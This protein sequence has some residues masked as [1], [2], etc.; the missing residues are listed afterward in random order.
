MQ[1]CARL[2]RWFAIGSAVAIL[3][4]VPASEAMLALAIGFLLLSGL[5]LRWPKI[6]IP[7]GLFILW[8]LLSL[9]ASP[10]PA[11]GLPQ[12]YKFLVFL[13]LLAVYSAV[14][15]PRPV[16]IGWATIGAVTASVGL[17]QF[18]QRYIQ[19]IREHRDFYHLYV[20]DRITG[21]QSHWMTFS[22]QL[23]YILILIGAFL[24]Y[25]PAAR[26]YARIAVPCGL[27]V[28]IALILSNTRGVWLAAI[29]AAFYL[30]WMWQRR[31]ALLLPA[32]VIL[33]VLIA[34][35][36]IRQRAMSLVR[37]EANTDSNSHRVIVWRTGWEMI[38][39]HPLL[40]VGPEEIAKH[41]VF[42]AYLPKDIPLP[43]PTGFY[44]HLHSIYIH[45]AAER[46]V[47]A[48]VF[49]TG[50]L[51]MALFDFRRRLKTLPPGRSDQRFILHWSSATVIGTM[52]VGASD[53]NLGLT[54]ELIMF[55]AA[56]SIGYK[57]A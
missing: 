57:A 50:A 56:M 46:G 30:L 28:A 23:L 5:P 44:E 43:L 3:V 7:L 41:D 6:A 27:A 40:G 4:S 13:T 38:K 48:A 9:A 54:P 52:V 14:D 51:A 55:L 19:A 35:S 21:F 49:L 8:T 18:G 32:V 47:P 33:L 17:I 42:F 10:D 25:A 31:A 37:P 11:A 20:N 22:G 24:L 36:A 1:T 45:Y 53:L 29:A 12:V 39:A 26:K 34:P 2:A 16:F 15:D